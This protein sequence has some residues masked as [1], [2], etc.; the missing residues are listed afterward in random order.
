MS[1]LQDLCEIEGYE[2]EMAMMEEF[3]DESCVPCIC[4][5]EGCDM[6]DHLE[7]D[8]DAGHCEECGTK[9]MKSF[10]ILMGVI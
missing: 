9:T 8:Q 7:P 6:T 5:N 2:D 1:K 4:M 3:F 10:M